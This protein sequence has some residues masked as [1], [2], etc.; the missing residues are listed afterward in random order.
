[1]GK[2]YRSDALAAVHETVLATRSSP[3]VSGSFPASKGL[4]VRIGCGECDE[5]FD[6]RR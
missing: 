6:A 2:K 5:V 1:M 3:I 4:L